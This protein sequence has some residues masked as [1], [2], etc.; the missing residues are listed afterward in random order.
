MKD[1]Y[2]ARTAK[3]DPNISGFLGIGEGKVA[4][5]KAAAAA[6]AATAAQQAILIQNLIDSAGGYNAE[7]AKAEADAAAAA[8]AAKASTTSSKSTVYIAVGVVLI[9]MVG[10]YF[11]VKARKK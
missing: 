3:Y 2:K 6:Q 1:N 4:N 7:K 5:A 11:I 10:L 9:L 8:A